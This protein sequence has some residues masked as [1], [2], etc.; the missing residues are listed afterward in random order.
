VTSRRLRH[1]IVSPH[2]SKSEV[3]DVAPYCV[4][5]TKRDAVTTRAV[6]AAQAVQ[7]LATTC[8]IRGSKP[9]GGAVFPWPSVLAPRT[10]QYSA[11]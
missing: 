3:P 8:T 11:Q 6:G 7:R 10:S 9:G 5:I 4:A 1:L 2:H